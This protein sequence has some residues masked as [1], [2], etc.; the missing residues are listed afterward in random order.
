[1][2]LT[3]QEIEQEILSLSSTER[4][5]LIRNLISKIDGESDDD[6]EKAWLEEAKRRYKE[7]QDGVVKPVPASDVIKRARLR[8]KNEG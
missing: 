1:M 2:A 8:I 6:V 5:D 7:L 4:D 3:L